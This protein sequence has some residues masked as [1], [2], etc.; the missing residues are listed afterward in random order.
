MVDFRYS[1]RIHLSAVFVSLVVIG[2]L[3]VAAVGFG[4]TKSIVERQSVEIFDRISVDASAKVRGL[5]A[6]TESMV[7]L[8][9]THSIVNARTFSER[10]WGLPFLREV[11]EQ[12]GSITSVFVGYLDGDFTLIRRYPHQPDAQARFD[13]PAGTAYVVQQ[14][15]RYDPENTVA[16]FR[17]YDQSMRLLGIETR[18]DYASYD[19]RV[20]PWF[21]DA[22]NSDGVHASNP[23]VFFTTK[24]I[25]T[26]ISIKSGPAVVAADI[27]LKTLVDEITSSLPTSG[28][29]IALLGPEDN[30]LAYPDQSKIMVDAGDDGKLRQAMLAELNAPALDKAFARIIDKPLNPG[31]ID[32]ETIEAGG[33]SWWTMAASI[34]A[35]GGQ[36]YTLLLAAPEEELFNQTKELMLSLAF[37]MLAVIIVAI[38]ATIVAAKFVAKPIK[39]LGD[40]TNHIQ[41][42]DFRQKS[43]TRSAIADVRDLATSIDSMKITI[44][45]FLE[46]SRTISEEPDFD[47]LQRR[48]LDETI[49][50]VGAKA[51]MI[52]LV[53]AD[54]KHLQCTDIRSARRQDLGIALDDL[55]LDDLSGPIAKAVSSR[56]TQLVEYSNDA[57]AQTGIP[58]AVS[59]IDAGIEWLVIVPLSN[60]SG[61]LVGLLV[62]LDDNA[63]DQGVVQFVTALSGTA[64]VA[65]ETRQ[66][67]EAQKQLFEAFIKLIAGAIDAKSSYTGGH[68]ERVP[69]LTNMLA[70]A[71][72]QQSSGPFAN[73][74]PDDDEWEAIHVASWLH[75]CGK[76]TTPEYIVD[77]ATKLETMYDRIHEIRMRFEVL[78][79][80]AW[81]EYWQ[82]RAAG[83]DDAILKPK[84]DAELEALDADFEFVAKSNVGGEFMDDSD[85]ERLVEIASRTWT[86]TLDDRLG[87]S[88]DEALRKAKFESPPLPV[89]EQL[90]ADK[91]EHVFARTQRDKTFAA[92]DNP[93]GFKLDEPENLFNRG[94]LYNLSIQRGTL[95]PE[96]RYKINEH[97]VQTIVM[98]NELPFP[99][100]LRK[101]PEIAGGHH[102]KMDGTGYPK[103]LKRE[104]MST[105]ARMMAIADIFEALTAVDRPYKK[106][107]TLTQ[108]LKIMSFMRNDAHIDPELFELFLKSGIYQSYAEK[109]MRPEQIDEVDINDYL[110]A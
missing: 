34:P 97:I 66:L 92:P 96:D 78:K 12:S 7:E 2:S 20:R 99:R 3:I 82:Q 44:Q 89:R 19:P 1:L 45:R 51:G 48:L 68:C 64:A 77:K 79:R 104:D 83:G 52:F 60:R 59:E 16:E 55:R 39:E 69:E 24:E 10:E 76:V 90:L 41:R 21:I 56:K 15:E 70:R 27:T 85:I 103:R 100:H 43:T 81:V 36:N 65:L 50:T 4:A 8:M 73:F 53:A 109:Y 11:L 94:E 58:K 74:K 28:S 110:D 54:E 105:V 37:W 72:Q 13:A 47:V 31:N 46:I 87:I 63:V 30:V 9:A 32:R 23:Y 18:P 33:K 98:L 93:W 106:G 102:E 6:P 49:S 5:F 80:D 40:E 22:L 95:T 29:D 107:K 108:S 75:D 101:V 38:L 42:F 62:L 67:I 26:T 57:F 86:R 88:Q 17:Y 84:L 35:G 14:I 71:A 91:P 61:D 25:G